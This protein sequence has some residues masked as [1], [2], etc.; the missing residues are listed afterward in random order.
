MAFLKEDIS[1]EIDGASLLSIRLRGAAGAELRTA[2]IHRNE[3]H[4]ESLRVLPLEENLHILV[5]GRIY[6]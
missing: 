5:L 4:R 6:Q 3:V 1:R 2:V